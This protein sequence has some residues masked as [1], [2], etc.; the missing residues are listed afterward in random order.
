M[1][2]RIGFSKSNTYISRLIRWAIDSP[3][4]H[5]YIRFYDEYLNTWL[6]IHADWPGVIIEDAQAYDLE[7]ETVVEYEIISTQNKTVLKDS[8]KFLKKKYNYWMFAKWAWYLYMNKKKVHGLDL[9]PDNPKKLICVE[10]V[11]FFIKNIA[12][13]YS[14][15]KLNP[16]ELSDWLE[17]N[18]QEFGW[19][20]YDPSK[21]QE[22]R[23]PRPTT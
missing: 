1:C 17:E 3:V 2:V 20:K 15:N 6:I 13:K 23:P 11:T 9:L 16:K 22:A 5:T 19:K 21:N 7:N 8:M 10:F 18:Y 14:K 12:P 4:S